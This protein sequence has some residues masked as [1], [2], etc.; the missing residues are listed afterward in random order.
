MQLRAA[1][2]NRSIQACDVYLHIFCPLLNFIGT[3]L[4]LIELTHAY[5][6]VETPDKKTVT[7]RNVDTHTT[8]R[9]VNVKDMIVS[10]YLP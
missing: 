1:C 7:R 8:E 2:L 6:D 5:T 4:Q 10:G 9:K 3:R